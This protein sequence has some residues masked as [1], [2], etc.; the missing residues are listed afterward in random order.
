[1]WRIRAEAAGTF[2]ERY[3]RFTGDSS[4]LFAIISQETQAKIRMPDCQS[5]RNIP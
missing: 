3:V 5:M 4:H 1:V 2:E